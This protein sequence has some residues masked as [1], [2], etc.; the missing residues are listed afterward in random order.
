M[1]YDVFV[2]SALEDRERAVLVVRRLRALKFKVWFDSKQ[3]D[4]TFDDKDARDALRS[5]AM[6]VLWSEAAVKSDW[7]RAAA[8]IGHSRPGT[9]VHASLDNAIPYE[10]FRQETRHD[11]AG[12]TSRKTVEGWF[13]AV[14]ALGDRNERADLRDWMA[15]G[16]KDEAAKASWLADHPNDPLSEYAKKQAAKKLG[17]KPEPAAAAAGAAAAAKAAIKTKGAP[18]TAAAAAGAVGVIPAIAAAVGLLLV[19]AYLARSTPISPAGDQIA[20]AC[21]RGEIPAA[22]LNRSRVLEPTGPIIDDTQ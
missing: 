18:P 3:T 20:A 15:I 13:D 9:L 22:L 7:V 8:S 11:I 16:P 1:A 17:K 12:L 4:T 6:L 19:F 21:P 2:V 14:D 10:P 5:N